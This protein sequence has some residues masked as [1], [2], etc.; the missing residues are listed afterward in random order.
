[1]ARGLSD[2]LEEAQAALDW[3][4]DA[5]AGEVPMRSGGVASLAVLAEE[6]RRALVEHA[7]QLAIARCGQ[8]VRA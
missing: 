1:M 6:V 4:A 2:I 5:L 7:R 8:A 3:A